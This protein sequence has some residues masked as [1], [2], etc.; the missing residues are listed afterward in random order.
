MRVLVLIVSGIILGLWKALVQILVLVH[1]FIVIF[2]NKRNKGIARFCEIWST[3]IYIL[4]RTT[5]WKPE[6]FSMCSEICFKSRICNRYKKCE[7]FFS[8]LDFRHIIDGWLVYLYLTTTSG[9]WHSIFHQ[10]LVVNW[11]SKI[12]NLLRNVTHFWHLSITEIL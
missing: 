6:R 10:A 3:Q 7:A 12:S 5:H 11:K 2:Q 8:I 1:W 4:S 9:S